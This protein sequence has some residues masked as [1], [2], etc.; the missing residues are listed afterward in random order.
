MESILTIFFIII[1][2]YVQNKINRI[3]NASNKYK[4]IENKATCK[5]SYGL[6]KITKSELWQ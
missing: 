1:S 4:N 6:N 5:P 2:Q 3:K